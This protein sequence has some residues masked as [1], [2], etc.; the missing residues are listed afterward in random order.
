MMEWEAENT[1]MILTEL[2]QDELAKLL[3]ETTE[4][5][6]NSQKTEDHKRK[7]LN[8]VGVASNWFLGTMDKNNEVN[9]E[10]FAILSIQKTI[11]REINLQE[12]LKH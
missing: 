7:I 5:W 12:S 10:I 2:D 1:E 11:A 9:Y 8:A 4:T 6:K 3:F